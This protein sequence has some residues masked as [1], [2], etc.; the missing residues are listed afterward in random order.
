MFP[1]LSNYSGES[2][3]FLSQFSENKD[4]ACKNLNFPLSSRL[5]GGESKKKE[6]LLGQHSICSPHMSSFRNANQVKEQ[7]GT[8]MQNFQNSIWMNDK[9][10]MRYSLQSKVIACTRLRYHQHV[11]GL[12]K[13]IGAAVLICSGCCL[14]CMFWPHF[15]VSPD[16]CP[17]NHQLFPG[18]S[19]SRYVS[20]SLLLPI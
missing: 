10:I 2:F 5:L 3:V 6:G 17:S 20:D 12:L 13:M 14:Y 9:K 7:A 15:F 18:H 4:P 11:L 8:H 16:F 1:D 19:V